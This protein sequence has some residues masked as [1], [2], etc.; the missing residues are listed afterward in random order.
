MP[1]FNFAKSRALKISIFLALTA[2]TSILML[3]WPSRSITASPNWNIAGTWDLNLDFTSPALG[4]FPHTLNITALDLQTGVFSGNGFYNASPSFSWDITGTVTD[5]SVAYQIIY[6]N[7]SAGYT[8]NGIGSIAPAGST[9]SGTF[10]DSL[11]RSG[12]WDASGSQATQLGKI[13]IAKQTLP[14][15]DS[16][17]FDFTGEITGS[18][19]DGQT[20]EKV[21]ESGSYTV[22]EAGEAGWDLTGLTCNDG[23]S[24]GDL[25]TL[26]ATFNVESGEIVTC[27]FTNTKRGQIIIEKTALGG[28]DTFGFSGD[29]GAFDITTQGGSASQQFEVVAGTYAVAETTIPAGWDLANTVCSDG[30]SVNAIDVTPGETVTCTF[31][32][33]KRGHIIVDKVT[34]PAGDPA[35]FDFTPNYGQPFSL[36]DQAAP[37]DSGPLV[38]GI[39][40][41]SESV[42]AGW[43]LTSATCDDGSDPSTIGLDPGETVTCTFTNSKL[44]T[45]T[46]IKEVI[47]DNGGTATEND[48]GLRINGDL[49]LSGVTT[50]LEVGPWYSINEDGISGYDFVEITGNNCPSALGDN[51]SLNPGEERVCTIVNDDQPASIIGL[52]FHDL[53]GDSIKDSNEPGLEGWTI[54]LLDDNG[55][56]LQSTTTDIDGNYSFPDL[57]AGDY[58]VQEVEQD[59]WVKTEPGGPYH[60]VTLTLGG[61]EVRNFGNY[62]AGTIIV[63]KVT[64]P[65]GDSESFEFSPSWDSNFFLA[66]QDNPHDSGLLLPGPYSVSEIVPNGWTLTSATCDDG[67]DPSAIDLGPGETVT[68]TFTNTKESTLTVNKIVNNNFGGTATIPDFILYIDGIPIIS[69]QATTTSIGQHMVS[70][71]QLPGYSAT[72][73]G[74]CD[75]DGKVTLAPGENKTCTITN[76][77]MAADL[78]VEKILEPDTDPGLFNL[79]IDSNIEAANVGDGGTTGP[80][81]LSAGLHT[82]S[83]TAGTGTDLSDYIVVFGGACD[84][85]GDVT[86]NNGESKT[87]TITNTRATGTLEIIKHIVSPADTGIVI[88]DLDTEYSDTGN[89]TISG[90]GPYHYSAAGVGI[91]VATWTPNLSSSGLYEVLVSWYTHPNRATDAPYTVN[92]DGGSQ[93]IDVNQQLLADGSPGGS[94][95]PSGWYSLGKFN[96]AT[97]TSGN[98]ELSDDANGYVI[99]DQVKF[100]KT[101]D[102]GLFDLELDSQ[103]ELADASDGDTTG[104]IAVNTGAHEVSESA[105]SNTDL[106][107]YGSD[108]VCRDQDGTGSIVA[109]ATNIGP[110]SVPVGNND[111]IVCIITNTHT[112]GTIEV[113]KDLNDIS[114]S[115]EAI[116]D[117]GDVEYVDSG[118]NVANNQGYNSDVHFTSAGSGSATATWAPNLPYSGQY[119]VFVNWTTHPNR[120]TDAPYTVNYDGGTQTIDVNQELLADQSTVGGSG[121]T[122][123]WYS[124]GTFNFATGTAGNVVLTNDADEYVIADAV[125][126]V[127]LG[128]TGVFDLLIDGSEEAIDVGDG[129]TT[130]SVSVLSGAHTVGEAEGTNTD[131]DNYNFSASCVDEFNNPVAAAQTNGDPEWSLAVETNE[132]IICTITNSRKTGSLEVVKNL[133]PDTDPGL[134]DLM[135]DGSVEEVDVSDGGSTGALE[136]TTGFHTINEAAGTGTDLANY[137]S[138]VEC[139]DQDGLGDIV[140]SG[141][142]PVNVELAENDTIVCTITNE[143]KMATVEG[144][145]FVDINGDGEWQT[146]TEPGLVGWTILALEPTPADDFDVDSAS[147]VPESSVVLTAGQDYLIK[148][149]GDYLAGDS[150]TADAKYSVRAPNS[151]WTDSVQNYESFGP[152]LLDL[153]ID[154]AS[155]DWGSFN[156][157]HDYYLR[158]TG[159]GAAL[160]FLVKDIHYPSN[161]GLL[162]VEIYKILYETTTDSNGYYI[163]PSLD[164]GDYLIAEQNQAGWILTSSPDLQPV[165][166]VE[167]VPVTDINFGN[168]QLGQ[169]SGIKY[170]DMNGNGFYDDGEPLLEGWEIQLYDDTNK[171]LLSTLT[172]SL[173]QYSFTNL[174]PG[175]YVVEE[176]QQPSYEQSQPGAPDFNYQFVIEQSGSQASGVNFGNYLPVDLTVF[177]YKDADFNGQLDAGDTPIANWTIELTNLFTGQESSGLTDNNGQVVFTSLRPG[178]Y[179][180]REVLQSDYIPFSPP[181]LFVDLTSGQDVT[182]GVYFLNVLLSKYLTAVSGGVLDVGTPYPL[183]SG[184]VVLTL[185]EQNPA[186]VSPDNGGGQN[187]GEPNQAGTIPSD[188]GTTPLNVDIPDIK[189]PDIKSKFESL[190]QNIQNKFRNRR[191]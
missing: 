152:E 69:G 151:L 91:D 52:K 3:S 81:S 84:A 71:D 87:C 105:G 157:N 41:V 116:I 168:F 147:S 128:G 160:D 29:L 129:G 173:G 131:L 183:D 31:T 4:A 126:F 117:D 16:Q 99:A 102:P 123:G 86:L 135:I 97:G 7:L 22:T 109:Q 64:N 54:E 56:F 42:P 121:Q 25:F 166:A 169:V 23:N 72:F 38:P 190:R 98:I 106:A 178:P 111:D 143:R 164:A 188:I 159:T 46:I 17:A 1:L 124:L 73:G 68:C 119:E 156:P 96:F 175:N 144:Y 113:I 187:S 44:P 118:W 65:S 125:R 186:P 36:T 181:A 142:A 60:P 148:V 100:I 50:T 26:T 94:I 127:Y 163:F 20:L 47:N 77:D 108:I 153:Q 112:G 177:K 57:V 165:T 35:S 122:S 155:P 74:D 11:G 51:V 67:S 182:S 13:I 40:A 18:L 5:D 189:L 114:T 62:Q 89:W 49:V 95:T 70:E 146:D 110:L 140:V 10:T 59:G 184:P 191:R 14:D 138:S 104:E 58:R 141:V 149:S 154:G 170:E 66:D 43:D 162:S 145:K 137:S 45:L 185:P 132:N 9:L 120:A 48:F 6:N 90:S 76:D 63:D 27:T 80:V 180:A 133:I 75:V 139:V 101:S 78:T 88:D 161:S 172:D 61:S 83:E 136:V 150:I 171:L 93:T 32:N 55:V 24:T 82:I 8:I 134:F 30:S 107:D 28:D 85:S 179:L 130:H 53:D 158:V 34:D 15:G 176:V 2:M 12:D 33:T 37:N 79:E 39:Y 21:V 103:V 115:F 167:G 92:Y 19:S 174:E